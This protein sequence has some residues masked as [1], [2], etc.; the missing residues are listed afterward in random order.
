M[1]IEASINNV[2]VFVVDG[3]GVLVPRGVRG[4]LCIGGVQVAREYLNRPELS[5]ELF[6]QLPRFGRVYK[7]GDVMRGRQDGI[8][9]FLGSQ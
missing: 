8:A 6:I 3:C 4:E 7:T 5:A 2:S 1:P 9:Q